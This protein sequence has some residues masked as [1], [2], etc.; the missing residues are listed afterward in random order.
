M[1]QIPEKGLIVKI[2]V[3]PTLFHPKQTRKGAQLPKYRN[4]PLTSRVRGFSFMTLMVL[5]HC[6]DFFLFL[7]LE[8]F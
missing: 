1:S 6:G 7:S 2:S 4:C 3:S 8:V 5:R